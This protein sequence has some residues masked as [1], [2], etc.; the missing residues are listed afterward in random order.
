[1][2]NRWAPRAF[3]GLLILGAGHFPVFAGDSVYGKLIN[4]KRADLV[5]L[6][7]GAGRYDIRI[8]GI[9]VPPGPL[10]VDA[11]HFVEKLVLNRNARMRLV[12]RAPG[13]DMVSQLLT[14][15]R[16]FGILDVGI[17][18]LRYGL[19]RWNQKYEYKYG[20]L[21]A[22]EDEARKRGLGLWAPLRTPTPLPTPT[23]TSTPLP[24]PTSTS[25]PLPVPTPTPT[26]TPVPP[27]G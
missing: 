23:P 16:R 14:D 26:L 13:G 18:L 11:Q 2:R 24:V 9:E 8:A 20:E 12:G 1:M 22:A 7:Y 19:A 10:A 15:D 6:D 17:E 21:K 25:T 3:L 5:I 27:I 4:V